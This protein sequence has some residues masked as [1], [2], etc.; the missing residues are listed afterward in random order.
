[1]SGIHPGNSKPPDPEVVKG[2][3]AA[4]NAR[5][6]DG[7][8][9]KRKRILQPSQLPNWVKDAILK[10]EID[11]HSWRKIA[12]K[13]GKSLATLADWA[14][15]PGGRIMR[16]AVRDVVAD[17]VATA[18]FLA[19]KDAVWVYTESVQH[20]RIAKEAG[21][22]AEAGRML[23]HFAEINNTKQQAGTSVTPIIQINLGQG[24]SLSTETPM[25][26][27]TSEKIEDADFEVLP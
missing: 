3:L 19:Q 2:K 5:Y 23:R 15:T 7:I 22:H 24:A 17:P 18:K 26:D 11:G 14:N 12:E 27:S 1:M 25:G 21:D 6:P 16:K 13:K 20:Y 4:L 10:H 8:P 9:P